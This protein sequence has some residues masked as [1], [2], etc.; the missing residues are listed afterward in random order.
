ML[1]RPLLEEYGERVRD[2]YGG[3]IGR[4][5]HALITPALVLDL[6]AAQ[7]NI[8][9]MATMLR[10]LP[11]GLRPHVKAHKSPDLALRQMA[12]GALGIS[13]A[14]IWEALV[15]ADAGLTDIFLVNQIVD[16]DKIGVAARLARRTTFR[17]AI[18]ESDNAQAWSAAAIA[19][20][21]TIGIML[22]VDT[23]MHRAG[24]T[25]LEAAVELAREVVDLPGLR[26]DGLTGYEGH[27]SLTPDRHKRRTQQ[28]AA[29]TTFVDVADAI[30]D[31]G[32]P[33]SILSAGGTA[34]WAWT[35][36]HPRIH[37]IQAGS[38]VLMD[39]EYASMAPDFEH[40]LTTQATVI[41][42]AGSRVVLDAGGKSIGEGMQARIVGSSLAPA[43]FDEEHGI[44]DASGDSTFRVGDKVAVIP[45]YAPATVN[46]FDAYHVVEDDRV[47]D[48]WPIVPRG[49][50]HAGL[51]GQQAAGR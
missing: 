25:S 20:G 14:T 5:R 41:S 9:R 38:Y 34:T 15:M 35:A 16:P 39:G 1:R 45:G 17:V 11:A 36:A 42:R 6:A 18:D 24:I 10:P 49:P 37:E 21:A 40:A 27:C 2:A 22:E 47:I 44:F 48:I 12:A 32:V 43:R 46:L 31:A 50:G 28:Q 4:H 8:D 30:V 13:A 19:A 23:G 51:A 7:R 33:V 3:A 29:M 26:F